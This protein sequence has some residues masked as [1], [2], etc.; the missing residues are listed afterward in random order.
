MLGLLAPAHR[1]TLLT[2]RPAPDAPAPSPPPGLDVEVVTYRP[3]SG[4][5]VVR[6]A[7]TGQ[8]LQSGL[9]FAPDLRRQLRRLAPRCDVAVLQLVRLAAHLDDLGDTPVIVDLID[10]LALNFSRRA[11]I[12]RPWLRPLWALEAR[13]LLRAE[14]R[15]ARCAAAVLLVCDRDRHYLERHLPGADSAR[16]ATVGLAVEVSTLPQGAVDASAAA[17]GASPTSGPAALVHDGDDG[18]PAGEPRRLVFTGN[19]GYFVNADAICWWLREVW[20]LVA[21]R[22][23]AVRLDVAGDRPTAAVRQAIIA[24]GG[25]AAGISLLE[26]APD[27]GQVLAGAAVA[28]APMRCG[29]GVPIKVLEAWAAGVPVVASPWAAAGTTAVLGDDLEVADTPQQWVDALSLLLSDPAAG[30]RLT[31]NGRR[32]LADDFSRSRVD[33]QLRGVLAGLP[34]CSPSR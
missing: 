4:L 32:R 10:D 15:L 31:D 18:A 24:A 19:L 26:S 14:R 7:A 23:P 27:L 20:P 12:D 28:L 2:P 13:L 34:A 8:P 17:A 11:A 29:S 25:A 3:G 1:V 5:G 22:N 9:F 21:A 33:Q 16:L 6:A 30:R